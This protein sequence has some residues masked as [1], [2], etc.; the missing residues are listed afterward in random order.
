VKKIFGTIGLFWRKSF[1]MLYSLK[2][3][4][5]DALR[6]GHISR[7]MLALKVVEVFNELAEEKLP[8][9]RKKDLLAISY[10][11]NII[12]VSCKNSA[13]AHWTMIHEAEI[14]AA[15]SRAVP[16]VR[17]EKIKTKIKYDF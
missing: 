11:D 12:N 16:E 9:G 5:P 2:D 15:L 4:L 17:V 13:A 1:S 3:L 6:R 8:I 7:E 10:K 14:I